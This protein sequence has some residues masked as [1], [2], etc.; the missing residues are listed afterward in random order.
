MLQTLTQQHSSVAQAL[1]TL[2]KQIQQ[3][4]SCSFHSSPW[5]H[6]RSCIPKR[7]L[8]DIQLFMGEINNCH[9]LLLVCPLV[10]SRSPR[11]FPDNTSKISLVS[12]RIKLSGRQRQSSMETQ[13]T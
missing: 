8:S 4:N 2:I 9:S 10:F 11:C 13:F 3:F 1:D 12:F 6:L 7:R 5:F